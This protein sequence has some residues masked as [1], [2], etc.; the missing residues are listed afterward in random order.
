MPTDS[1][2]GLRVLVHDPEEF[3]AVGERGFIVGPGMETQV[4]VTA[5]DTFSAEVLRAF[6]A[7]RR[8]CYFSDEFPLKY[9]KEYSRSSCVLECENNYIHEKCGCVPYYAP[10]TVHIV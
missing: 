6:A 8:G 5:T 3:P 1:F 10:G 9:Y 7:K 2:K 4:A